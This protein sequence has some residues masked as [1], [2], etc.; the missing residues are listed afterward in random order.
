MVANLF[1][2]WQAQSWGVMSKKCFFFK[3]LFLFF[4]T[5]SYCLFELVYPN[6]ATA[7]IYNHPWKNQRHYYEG[8]T[9]VPQVRYFQSSSNYS[10]NGTIVTSTGFQEA[11]AWLFD[12]TGKFVIAQ[13][14]TFYGR[15]SVLNL[16]VDHTDPLKMGDGF[17]LGDQAAGLNWWAIHSKNGIHVN[18]QLQ[19]DIPA[20]TV[21]Q[22]AT[23]PVFGDGTHN[24]TGGGFISVPVIEDSI[25]SFR[26]IAGTGLMVRTDGFSIA[27][28]WT[29]SAELS[30]LVSGVNL[31]AGLQGFQSIDRQAGSIGTANPCQNSGIGDSCFANSQ[32]PSYL[33]FFTEASYDF[34]EVLRLSAYYQSTVFGEN[35]PN[36]WNSGIAV[37]FQV[38]G[39]K[40][41]NK[42]ETA[43]SSAAAAGAQDES[44]FIQ[45]EPLEAQVTRM[46]DRLNLIKI[47]KGSNQGVRAGETY[48]VFS[49]SSD[50]RAQETIARAR[51]TSVRENEAA[52]RVVRYLKEVWIEEGFIVRRP[53]E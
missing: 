50:G 36:F 21:S 27:V 52:L 20:Y 12:V 30:Q 17:G 24:F 18:L 8:L 28:P 3:D 34:S 23:Q 43:P 31:S 19:W 38:F 45:Y 2:L 16:S 29:V 6:S 32:D 9:L 26:F 51:V 35:S 1:I 46:N 37:H 15:V 22:T 49:V 7:D 25:R 14:F 13:D 53:I 47:N 41:R 10:S 39:K 42:F 33:S 44:E 5:G 11:S 4:L 40:K 48:D